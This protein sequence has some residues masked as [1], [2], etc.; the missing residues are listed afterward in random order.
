MAITPKSS[1][2]VNPALRRRLNNGRGFEMPVADGRIFFFGY[3]H[4]FLGN[5]GPVI[6]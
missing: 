5:A 4:V 3:H 2:S 1:M 6:Y